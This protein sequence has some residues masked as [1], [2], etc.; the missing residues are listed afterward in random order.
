MVGANRGYIKT[1]G[2]AKRLRFVK[3]GYDATDESVPPNKVIFDS[4][5]IATAAILETG[6]QT[7]S[8]FTNV[9]LTRVS[10]WDYGFVPLCIIHWQYNETWKRNTLT[11][12]EDTYP[13]LVK[14]TLD[15]LYAQ[16]TIFGTNF[17]GYITMHWTALAIDARDG[18]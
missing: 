6:S 8:H 17:S 2:S 11:T 9:P 1:S 5:N 12:A 7:W 16:F 3:P 18:A 10:A 14:S 4:N 13:R 15:G